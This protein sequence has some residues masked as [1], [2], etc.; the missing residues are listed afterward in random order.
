MS[1]SITLPKGRYK[2]TKS[3]AVNSSSW[4]VA[5]GDAVVGTYAPNIVVGDRFLAEGSHFRDYISTS[6]VKDFELLEDNKVKIKTENSIYLLEEV[7][8]SKNP[9]TE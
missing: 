5:E 6:I 7:D 2:C 9:L 8:S 3:K 1:K 4:I